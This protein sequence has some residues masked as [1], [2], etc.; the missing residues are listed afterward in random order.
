MA[1]R[2]AASS[3]AGRE[4]AFKFLY[5]WIVQSGAGLPGSGDEV[6]GELEDF[7][8]HRRNNPDHE[9]DL[10]ELDASARQ[11]ALNLCNAYRENQVEL[12][13]L[14]DTFNKSKTLDTMTRLLAVLGSAEILHLKTPEKVVM[15]EYVHLAKKYGAPGSF[16]VVN[17]ILDKVSKNA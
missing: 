8:E 7:E 1:K 16:G 3:M 6:R 2:P 17:A 12:S 5:Q 4:F 9:D 14:V 11:M 10:P 15:N 13:A